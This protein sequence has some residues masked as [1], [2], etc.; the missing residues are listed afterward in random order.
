MVPVGASPAQF[1][2]PDAIDDV[3]V[4]RAL[5]AAAEDWLRARGAE[6]VSGPFSPSINSECGLLVE[7]HQAT[8]MFLMPWHPAYLG[9]HLDALGYEKARDLISYRWGV[10]DKK[11][12]EKPRFSLRKEWNERLKVRTIDMSRLK[13][14]ETPIMIELF[15]DAWRGNWAG[16]SV[17]PGQAAPEA[18]ALETVCQS[19][20]VADAGF[21]LTIAPILQSAVLEQE[22]IAGPRK[23]A[24]MS[25]H[26][27]PVKRFPD[28]I[29]NYLFCRDNRAVDGGLIARVYSG[30]IAGLHYASI[31]NFA[32]LRGESFEREVQFGRL[33]CGR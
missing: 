15:N 32:V 17:G 28:A 9:R 8:P 24:D 31:R 7:G 27:L 13:T 10:A 21:R 29:N 14:Q 18:A 12:D 30:G 11:L 22:T 23:I 33:N 20:N 5:L 3:D 26:L 25:C 1:G 16:W 4:V 19:A 2:A 6:R